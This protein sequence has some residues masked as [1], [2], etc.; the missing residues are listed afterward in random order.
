M[1]RFDDYTWDRILNCADL[2]FRNRRLRIRKPLKMLKVRV[3]KIEG[4]SEEENMGSLLGSES[5]AP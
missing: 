4:R 1:K 2:L 5:V 3:V